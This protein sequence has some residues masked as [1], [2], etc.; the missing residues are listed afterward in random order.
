MNNTLMSIKLVDGSK[1]TRKLISQFQPHM[2]P[3]F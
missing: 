2:N 3:L 1:N